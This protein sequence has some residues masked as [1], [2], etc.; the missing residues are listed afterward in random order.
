MNISLVYKKANRYFRE[1]R[2]EIIKYTGRE[3]NFDEELRSYKI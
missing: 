3:M 1:E 2:G